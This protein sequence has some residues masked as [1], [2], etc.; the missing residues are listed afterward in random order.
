M[1]NTSQRSLPGRIVLLTLAMLAADWTIAQ[2]QVK[3]TSS[4]DNNYCNGSCTLLSASDLDG[5]P[6]AIIFVTPV[7]VNG[8]SLDPH[9]DLCLL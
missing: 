2:Q 7:A 9:P 4:K 6:N 5:N 3:L 8:A 1:N